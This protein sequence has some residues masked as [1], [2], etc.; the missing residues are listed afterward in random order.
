MSD[1]QTAMVGILGLR[2][3]PVAVRFIP[4]GEPLPA[5]DTPN[6]RRFC[7]VLMEARQGAQRLLTPEN[8]SCPAVAAAL[9]F[10]P[11]PE[12]L[13]SGEML[14][15]FGVFANP[16]AARRTIE[17]MHRLPPGAYTAV[18]VSPLGSAGFAPDVVIVEAQPEQIMWLT[19]AAVHETGG[20]LEFST[21]VLQ[22][23]C[24]D[25]A[26]LP[27]VTG[28]MNASFG[29]YGCREATDLAE[30]ECVLGIPG[31]MLDK[32][33]MNLERLAAK[34]I[35]KVRGKSTYRHFE[36]RAA[37]EHECSEAGGPGEE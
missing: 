24:V 37:S 27:F 28:K 23:T 33:T 12:K 21:G 11:L 25:A 9:G 30:E 34:A 1:P 14:V 31:P 4:H 3:L 26:I 18:A 22:A 6:R 36:E 32:V 13:A 5:F 35:P 16:G 15:G 2:S 10:K 7:Q 8:V 29:C 19:L 17:S 20:R